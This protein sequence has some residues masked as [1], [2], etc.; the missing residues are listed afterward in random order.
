M[1]AILKKKIMNYKM[2]MIKPNQSSKL[3][4]KLKKE[5]K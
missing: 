4:L 2:L 1:Q 3:F 5:Q